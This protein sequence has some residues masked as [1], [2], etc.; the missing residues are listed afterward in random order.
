M[1]LI[2]MFKKEVQRLH[3]TADECKAQRRF[4]TPFIESISPG[5][6]SFS[7]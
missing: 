6:P 2:I 1:C 5:F 3:Q 7:Q 4:G